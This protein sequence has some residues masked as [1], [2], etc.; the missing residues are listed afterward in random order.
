[1]SWWLWHSFHASALSARSKV[2]PVAVF[3]GLP[4]SHPHAAAN[5]TVATAKRKLPLQV[6]TFPYK[7]CVICKYLKEH[8]G[9]PLKHVPVHWQWT[10]RKQ[11]KY[12]H[13]PKDTTDPHSKGRTGS[14]DQITEEVFLPSLGNTEKKCLWKHKSPL[15]I[16]VMTNAD[17]T[18]K[19]RI[20][21]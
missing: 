5:W 1:M 2:R 16:T 8:V 11:W 14:E 19:L 13:L 21:L 9:C 15:S 12:Q 20:F 4:P 3:P 18:A 6:K 7:K 10:S 17:S